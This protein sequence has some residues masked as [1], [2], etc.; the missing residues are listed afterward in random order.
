[1]DAHLLGTVFR[2]YRKGDDISDKD[3]TAAVTQFHLLEHALYA[4]GARFALA[5]EAIGRVWEGLRA[6]KN[7]RNY[8]DSHSMPEA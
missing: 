3:L 5:R 4:L 2:A 6:M 7:N 8:H 1:M